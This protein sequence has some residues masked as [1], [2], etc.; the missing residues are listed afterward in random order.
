MD[1]PRSALNTKIERLGKLVDEHMNVF[2]IETA[3]NN[4]MF[5]ARHRR[6]WARTRTSSPRWTG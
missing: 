1:P 2:H 4:R 6:S 5:H 3:L